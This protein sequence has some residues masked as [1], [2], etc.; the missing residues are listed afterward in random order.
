MSRVVKYLMKPQG[1]AALD[2]VRSPWAG[3]SLTP[4]FLGTVPLTLPDDEET[5]T[6]PRTTIVRELTACVAL[7]HAGVDWA[8]KAE[9]LRFLG[10]LPEEVTV[11]RLSY[12]RAQWDAG[13][14]G[15]HRRDPRE[16]SE[17]CRL[18]AGGPCC[19]GWSERPTTPDLASVA[20][21][22]T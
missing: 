14:P 3:R 20:P 4:L 1:A 21:L 19:A 12:R 22:E 15:R 8:G 17:G 5:P 2:N 7:R 6:C 10:H 13:E 18:S 11:L 16:H 9:T